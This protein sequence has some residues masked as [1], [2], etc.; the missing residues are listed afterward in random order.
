MKKNRKVNLLKINIKSWGTPV[1]KQFGIKRLPTYHL[2]EGRRLVTKKRSRVM[3][4]M[5]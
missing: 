1:T 5:R 2:Y 3:A 4:A